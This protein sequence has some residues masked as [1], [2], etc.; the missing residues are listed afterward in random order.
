MKKIKKQPTRLRLS[1][2]TIQLL[3]HTA[4]R[5]AVGGFSD[6]VNGTT[7]EPWECAIYSVDPQLC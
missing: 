4:L 3:Q 5:Q 6:I 7:C 1:R 2:E